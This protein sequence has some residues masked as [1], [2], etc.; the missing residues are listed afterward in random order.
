[1]LCHSS[2]VNKGMSTNNV[3]LQFYITA[4]AAT[5]GVLD[6][7]PRPQS[8]LKKAYK[9]IAAHIFLNLFLKICFPFGQILITCVKCSRASFLP[10]PLTAK[11]CAGDEIA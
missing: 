5:E 6:F 3:I 4:G 2:N 9:F 7:Q 10:L 8:N 1:M 11:R